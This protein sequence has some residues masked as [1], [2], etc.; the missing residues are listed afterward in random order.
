MFDQNNP[1][2]RLVYSTNPKDLEPIPEK[3]AVFPTYAEQKLRFFLDRQGRKGKTMTVVEGI[4]ASEKDRELW[5]K[6]LKKLCGAGGNLIE[7]G[8]QIQGEHLAKTQDYFQKLGFSSKK[9]G[10]S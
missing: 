7:G 2:T 3:E 10:G 6:E 4:Q 9:K 5:L 1:K 8:L